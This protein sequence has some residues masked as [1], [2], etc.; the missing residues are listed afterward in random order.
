MAERNTQ[1]PKEIEIKPLDILGDKS[2]CK[3]TIISWTGLKS[4]K[5]EIASYLEVRLENLPSN[6]PLRKTSC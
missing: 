2:V 1:N 6:F 3:Q 5:V 4:L